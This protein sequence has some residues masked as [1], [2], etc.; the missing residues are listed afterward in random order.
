MYP[1]EEARLS[2][3]NIAIC[4]TKKS[5]LKDHTL[6]INVCTFSSFGVHCTTIPKYVVRC[7]IHI[8]CITYLHPTDDL[9]PA[10]S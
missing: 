1:G 5:H 8:P 3:T 9:L 4:Q 2:K 7:H 10:L 6:N